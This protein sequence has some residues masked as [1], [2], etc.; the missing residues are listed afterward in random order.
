MVLDKPLDEIKEE[1]LA[2]LIDTGT[3]ELKTLDYKR[4]LPGTSDDDRKEFLADVSSFAN[5]AGGHLIF[6]MRADEGVPVELSGVDE[7]GD[8]EILRLENII[9]D[10]IDPRITGIHSA[11]IKLP[12]SR[13]AI[14]TRIPKSFS[15]PH[16]VKF[17]NTSRFYSRASNGKYQL[18]VHQIRAAFLGSETTAERI[19]NFRLERVSQIRARETAIPLRAGPCTALHI[20]PLS[21]FGS[22]TRY[23]VIALRTTNIIYQTLAPLFHDLATHSK[24]NFDGRLVYSNAGH[25]EGSHGF[26]QLYRSGI[27]ET[28]DAQLISSGESHDMGKMI[29]SLAFE[30]RLFGFIQRVLP[31]LKLL[32][33]DPPLVLMLTL[34]GVRGYTM[35]SHDSFGGGGEPFDREVLMPQEVLIDTYSADVPLLMKPAVDEIWNAANFNES[36]YYIDGKWFGD[37]RFRQLGRM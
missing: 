29:S 13:T 34:I 5:A 16:M 20:I 37:K 2:S 24:I 23:D 12:R 19:R 22:S 3:P 6:G 25:D 4:S 32:G 9:R 33:V 31:V 26:L 10:G 7:R 17:K 14:V 15:S 1:D 8:G 11:A 18:D 30:V 28:V 35:S 21:A 36:I 27:V